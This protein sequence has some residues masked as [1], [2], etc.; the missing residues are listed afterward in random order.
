[1]TELET[2]LRTSLHNVAQTT[3]IPPLR[4]PPTST[5]R[6][7]RRTR[8]LH[9]SAVAIATTAAVLGGG[10]GIAAATG[11]TPQSLLQDL[12]WADP[13][14]GA[15]NPITSSRHLLMT[16][17]GPDGKPMEV[18]YSAATNHGY[19]VSLLQHDPNTAYNPGTDRFAAGGCSGNVGDRYWKQFGSSAFSS[20]RTFAA[21]VP[22]AVTV[23]LVLAD[24]TSRRLQVAEGWVAATLTRHE[25]AANPT[26][27]GYAANGHQIG[28]IPAPTH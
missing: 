2:R 20:G 23:R 24:R 1:M 22:G 27:V 4:L 19:C 9:R 14:P 11:V 28:R 15:Y 6:T 26:I 7:P 25:Q 18:W 10:A 16:V 3:T 21:H 13:T 8:R 12:G 17:P 5:A